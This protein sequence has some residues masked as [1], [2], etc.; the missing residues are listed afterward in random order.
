MTVLGVTLI[1]L[2]LLV[3]ATMIIFWAWVDKQPPRP[4][5][6]VGVFWEDRIEESDIPCPSCGGEFIVPI[7][8]E[9]C[10]FKQC[11]CEVRKT[12]AAEVSELEEIWSR[13]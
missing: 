1:V 4:D 2:A 9:G 10:C 8:N 3:P 6:G 12:E 13:S 7:C 11:D 5:C